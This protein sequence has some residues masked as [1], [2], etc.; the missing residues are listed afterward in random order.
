M[1]KNKTKITSIMLA[2]ALLTSSAVVCN[3]SANAAET[4]TD[5]GTVKML[6]DANGDGKISVAD[7]TAVQ[8]AVSES[9]EF[10]DDQTLI[11]DTNQDGRVTIADVTLIQL[12]NARYDTLTNPNIGK[13]YHDAEYKTITHPAETG[14]TKL[15]Y[16][17]IKCNA[18]TQCNEPL[19]H[20]ETGEKFTDDEI[21]IHM[22]EKH[23]GGSWRTENV[24][25]Y[26]DDDGIYHDL[27]DDWKVPNSNYWRPD[28]P[29]HDTD[30]WDEGSMNVFDVGFNPYN[31]ALA[32]DNYNST[33]EDKL[34]YY[35]ATTVESHCS[36][37][38]SDGSSVYID[39]YK[40]DENG[41]WMDCLQL[42]DP[43]EIIVY[44]K[45]MADKTA[46]KEAKEKG[47]Q[48]V[49]EHKAWHA[50]TDGE[51]RIQAFT[52]LHK[53]I[54]EPATTKDAWTETVLVRDAGWY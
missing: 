3:I 47:N 23:N 31:G 30:Y 41:N 49:A 34:N 18:C 44:P 9:T 25:F 2:I 13:I 16:E 5:T 40:K 33:H 36:D 32:Q 24:W 53:K 4:N 43:V 38:N 7:A 51:T 35:W 42:M 46:L 27:S 37:C 14:K 1:K 17:L 12:Y 28:S 50:K 29:W 54:Y 48:I 6:G 52:A 15:R 45:D 21:T 26:V 39:G 22:F 19:V 20:K 11:M 8:L 10:T